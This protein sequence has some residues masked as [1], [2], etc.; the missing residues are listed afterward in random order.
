MILWLCIAAAYLILAFAGSA[1]FVRFAPHHALSR[2]L[3]RH[4][5]LFPVAPPCLGVAT[6]FSLAERMLT[7]FGRL[8]EMLS[9][10]RQY[11]RYPYTPYGDGRERR[12][13]PGR[14]ASDKAPDDRTDLGA[15][16]ASVRRDTA[17][18]GFE[19][20]PF[21]ANLLAEEPGLPA[22]RKFDS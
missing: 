10:R 20:P 8:F 6:L 4:L 1:M 16:R 3:R 5:W 18:P 15:A 13:G 14:R 7:G 2:T 9:G 12:Q 21:A 22:V 19:H 17:D 11:V